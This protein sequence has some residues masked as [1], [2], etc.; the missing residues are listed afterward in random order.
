MSL[1]MFKP[2]KSSVKILAIAAGKGG[3]GKSTLTANLA[4]AMKQRGLKVGVLDA[5]IYGP[6]LRRMLP[7]DRLPKQEGEWI[8]PAWSYGIRLLS[9]SY[10][11]PENQAT[12]VRA[13]IANGMIKKFLQQV[14]WGD[15]DYLLIDFPPG[16]GDIQIT[17]SQQANLTGAVMITTPQEISLMDVRKALN[18]FEQL[19]VPVLGIVENMSFYLL[20]DKNREYPFGNG[21]GERLA[22]EFAVPL[23]AQIPIHASIS[24]AGD[25]GSSLFEEGPEQLQD[26]FLNL[27]ASIETKCS[28][29]QQTDR[30]G[31]FELLWKEIS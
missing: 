15:L 14:S 2:S 24:S 18:L 10:F 7:E 11:R 25:T 17:L 30:L 28:Q 9:I 19:H 3:V 4:L 31:S 22:K 26:I 5:D 29:L 16:T 23:L 13:P 20:D 8:I 21:G 6:S 27:S 12:A 1:T